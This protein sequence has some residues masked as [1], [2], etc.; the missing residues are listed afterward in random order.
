MVGLLAEVPDLYTMLIETMNLQRTID[1]SAGYGALQVIKTVERWDLPPYILKELPRLCKKNAAKLY[2]LARAV[3]H[4]VIPYNP[5]HR[6]ELMQILT[7]E[8]KMPPWKWMLSAIRKADPKFS[9]H[10]LAR[11]LMTA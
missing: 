9:E 3:N 4:S 1:P 2:V 6:M 10:A 11:K 5:P 8:V 7:G